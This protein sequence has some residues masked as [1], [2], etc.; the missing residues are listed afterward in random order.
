[1]LVFAFAAIISALPARAQ[2]PIY[3]P[4]QDGVT[5]P[6]LTKEVKPDYTEE[7]KRR[8][9]QGSVEL[10]AV[11]RADGSV[12]DTHVTKSL[13]PDLDQ[14]AVKA[15]KQWRFKPA[16]KAGTPVNVEVAIELTFT[17]RENGPV[18]NSGDTGVKMPEV[19]KSVNPDYDDA[20]RQE[21]VQGIV[22][23]EGI[24]EPN[25][26]VSN[27]HVTKSLDQRLDRQAI[28]AFTQWSFNPGQKDGIAVRVT[29]HVEMSFTL[30]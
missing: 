22:E 7:A 26:T 3:H 23:L 18:Y 5:D 19:V 24:V 29:V 4:G 21:R 13:D 2:E 1:M 8:Q 14:Q 30:K 17:L 10:S 28:K 6:V 9:V 16:T 27:I 11:V 20:A 25:G 12:G 15:V